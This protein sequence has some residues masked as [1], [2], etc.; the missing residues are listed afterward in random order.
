MFKL[1]HD[2]YSDFSTDIIFYT[3]NVLQKNFKSREVFQFRF[4]MTGFKK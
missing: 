2:F 1:F 3:I 4:G